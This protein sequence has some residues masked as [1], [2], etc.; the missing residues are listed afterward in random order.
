VKARSAPV[1]ALLL[2]AARPLA[3]QDIGPALDPAQLGTSMAADSAAQRLLRQHYAQHGMTSGNPAGGNPAGAGPQLSPAAFRYA[4]SLERRKHNLARFAAVSRRIDPDGAARMERVFASSDIIADL[5]RQLR[6]LG[7]RVDDV[8]DAYAVWWL[9]AWMA[10]RGQSGIPG[11][12]QMAAV[13]AQAAGALAATQVATAGDAVKQEMAEAYLVQSLLIDSY[14]EQGKT[15]PARMRRIA[16]AVK[17]GARHTGMDLDSMEL[18]P[19]G[20]VPR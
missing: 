20:F 15:D 5:Q 19:H 16:A 9:D 17:Q 8:A 11:R 14:V 2:L 18:T 6:P 4:P 10:S 13:R 7:L 3:A 1:A 12:A